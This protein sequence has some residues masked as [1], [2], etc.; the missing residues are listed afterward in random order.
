MW[1]VKIPV[2][3]ALLI[4]IVC[5]THAM[6]QHR[7]PQ[8]HKVRHKHNLMH[9]N[10]RHV[11]EI[12]EAF[13]DYKNSVQ[14]MKTNFDDVKTLKNHRKID[15]KLSDELTEFAS[16]D[17]VMNGETSIANQQQLMTRYKR[18]HTTETTTQRTTTTVTSKLSEINYDEEYDDDDDDGEKTSRKTNNESGVKVQVSCIITEV[19]FDLINNSKP[20]SLTQ[21]QLSFSC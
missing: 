3:L 18:V 17:R 14:N 13:D 16:D 5:H 7:I 19:Q 11:N 8:H 9:F 12:R 2:C 6:L 15:E 21:S 4:A 1:F 20:I 10:D